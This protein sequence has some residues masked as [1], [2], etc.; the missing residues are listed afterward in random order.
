M[1]KLFVVLVIIIGISLLAIGIKI[2]LKTNEVTTNSSFLPEP[3]LKL[4]VKFGDKGSYDKL[5]YLYFDD[6]RL[7]DFIDIAISMAQNYKYEKAYFDIYSCLCEISNNASIGNY[8]L[9]NLSKNEKEMAIYYLKKSAN[10]GNPQSCRILGNYYL[11]GRYVC[12]DTI[13]GR[14]LVS[15]F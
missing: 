6:G 13:L 9:D 4:A 14:K 15:S 8:S 11:E 10:I 1:K 5:Y 3:I 2:I 7:S 12:Q